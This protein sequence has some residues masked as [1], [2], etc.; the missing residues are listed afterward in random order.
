VLDGKVIFLRREVRDAARVLAVDAQS[1]RVVW[2]S[3]L[4][5]FT[6][7]P[8]VC[9]DNPAAICVTGSLAQTTGSLFRFDGRTGRFLSGSAVLRSSTSRELGPGLFDTGRRQP[10]LL[11][12]TTGPRLA[13]QR[14]L[15]SVFTLGRPSTDWGWNFDRVGRV[16][17]FVGTAGWPPIR[18]TR[19][20]VV[21]DLARTMTA[22]FRIRDGSVVWRSRGTRYVCGILPCEG[23]VQN[24][25]SSPNDSRYQGPSVGVRLREVGTISGRTSGAG[26]PTPSRG[27]RAIVE[28]FDPADGRRRWTFDAGRSPGLITFASLPPQVGT[29]TVVVRDR[30]GRLAA[31]NLVDGSHRHVSAHVSGWCNAPI[32]YKLNVPYQAGGGIRISDYVGAFARFPCAVAGGRKPTPSRVPAFVGAIGAQADGLIAWSDTRGF[33][34]APR[35]D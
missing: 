2:Q 16:G 23:T 7:W 18:R 13:W 11:A 28:G 22:G 26:L 14:P 5:I 4:G 6:S 10:E 17:L 27:A 31:L 12:A 29:N 34:A 9:F 25:V 21:F 8:A 32:F 30:T 3:R 24:G 19:D 33:F 35:G 15:R 1:G 20:R